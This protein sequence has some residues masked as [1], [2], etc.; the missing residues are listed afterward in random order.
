[1]DVGEAPGHGPRQRALGCAV[2]GG[3]QEDLLLGALHRHLHDRLGLRQGWHGRAGPLRPARDGG[4][5]VHGPAASHHCQL[6][7]G[8]REVEEPQSAAL[9]D[10]RQARHGKRA[11]LRPAEHL[12]HGLG[13]R[14]ARRLPRGA[15]RDVRQLHRGERAVADLLSAD[16]V[17]PAVGVRQ[18][19]G[20]RH[21]ALRRLR[22][23]H[24]DPRRGVR[25]AER[26]QLRLGLRRGAAAQPRRLRDAHA[27]GAGAPGVL[28]A[29]RALRAAV[30]LRQGQGGPEPH[31]RGGCGA[32]APARRDPG[33]AERLEPHLGPGH[34]R[35]PPGLARGRRAGARGRAA[36]GHAGP[37]RA[38]G[39]GGGRHGHLG[40]LAHRP[41]PRRLDALRPD[42]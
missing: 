33:P 38:R 8:L 26:R 14:D 29:G 24:R 21:A 35:A 1:M 12:Q 30:G 7:V 18:G 34:D 10:A 36:R 28:P 13:L 16:G 31:L 37:A 15:V 4:H 19:G 17:Q 40:L 20:H 42:A 27:L 32:A 11:V 23:V 6:G 39:H 22:R 3:C 5:G 9:R 25:H 2:E 41:L